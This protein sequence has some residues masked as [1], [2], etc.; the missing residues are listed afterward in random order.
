MAIIDHYH[1]LIR[2][3]LTRPQNAIAIIIFMQLSFSQ[4]IKL[5]VVIDN[6]IMN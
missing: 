1:K 2:T 4:L 6:E 3:K 5:I